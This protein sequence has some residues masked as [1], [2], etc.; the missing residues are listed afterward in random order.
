MSDNIGIIEP[1]PFVDYLPSPTCVAGTEVVPYVTFAVSKR[2]RSASPARRRTSRRASPRRRSDEE[3][4]GDDDGGSAGAPEDDGGDA[5]DGG[6]G[7]GDGGED[8]DD[9]GDDG[10]E[11]EEADAARVIIQGE[12]RTAALPGATNRGDPLFWKFRYRRDAR[13][14]DAC[15]ICGPSRW[16][17]HDKA[18]VWAQMYAEQIHPHFALGSFVEQFVDFASTRERCF[19]VAPDPARTEPPECPIPGLRLAEYRKISVSHASNAE[20]SL[21]V[22]VYLP[23]AAWRITLDPIERGPQYRC[24]M[25]WSVWTRSPVMM[26]RLIRDWTAQRPNASLQDVDC[27]AEQVR[28]PRTGT[29]M[30]MAAIAELGQGISYEA[31]AP[32]AAGAAEAPILPAL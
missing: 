7:G 28:V 24:Y 10:E 3:D 14:F 13:G 17:A 15:W 11:L 21:P 22:G 19:V 26:S 29:V 4:D 12:L 27:L 18:A 32:A 23:K 5:G 2:R 16:A 31:V 8:G 1:F 20:L 25:L 30:T 6:D 9:D